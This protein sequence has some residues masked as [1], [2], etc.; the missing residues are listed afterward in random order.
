MRRS[1]VQAMGDLAG[2]AIGGF[3]GLIAD[4]QRAAAG[5]PYGLLG[6]VA[7]PV[8][9]MHEGIART[10]NG[11]V[12]AGLTLPARAGAAALAAATPDTAP[13]VAALPRGSVALGALNGAIGDLLPQ[14]YGGLA[15]DMTVRRRGA[16]VTLDSEAI[17]AAYP[18][19]GPRVAVFV[20]G[21]CETD[22]AWRIGGGPTYGARLE[23]DLGYTPVHLRYNSGLH[24][25]ENGR[26][27]ADLLDK[28]CAAW[29]VPVDDLAL[30][31]HSMGGLVSRSACHY[32]ERD[33]AAWTQALR[34]V[35]CLGTP[36][37]GAPLERAANVAGWALGR[38]PETRPFAKVV[39]GRSAGIKDM[40]YGSCVE[41]DW[42]D[43]DADEFLNDRCTEVPFLPSAR[44]WFIGATLARRPGGPL[45]AVVGDLLV[46]FSSASGKGKKRTLPFEPDRGR[47]LGGLTHF[48]LLNHP[49]VYEQM[50][51]WLGAGGSVTA[52][53]PEAGDT[54]QLSSAG[55]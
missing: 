30:V 7:A 25:S 14:R 37:M 5:R 36:H 24:V 40:R 47:H 41:E 4:V 29:P 45:D 44:Y 17:A 2:D 22:T 21:L 33:G 50:R 54:R 19:A 8:R 34:D 51:A 13:A 53:R 11:A 28:L 32:G 12:R 23:R 46:A 49:Q 42:C 43:C 38:L 39:N 27:L 1:D 35:V 6:P 3:V 26:R 20:H 48:H 10:V 55:V 9:V 15:L 16:D 52:A 31:G 18:G